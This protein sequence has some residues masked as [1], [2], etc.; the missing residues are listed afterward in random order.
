MTTITNSPSWVISTWIRRG[1]SEQARS[2]SIL[3]GIA[4]GFATL[5]LALTASVSVGL[6]HRIDS[7]RWTDPQPAAEPVAVQITTTRYVDGHQIKVIHLAPTSAANETLP[8]PPGMDH[9]PTPGET[10]VSPELKRLGI[11]NSTAAA[12]GT[13]SNAA[14][15]G[16][17][18]LLAVVG[19]AANDPAMSGPKLHDVMREGEH[20]GPVGISD[21]GGA[22]PNDNSE[23]VQY[24]WLTL[25]ATVLLVVPALS[26]AASGARLSASRRSERLALL[27]LAGL[28]RSNLVRITIA[29]T[30]TGA[31]P[32]VVAG[33]AIYIAALPLTSRVPLV[34]VRWFT[35]DL[36]LGV[37]LAITI[38]VTVLGLVALSALVPLRRIL[39]DPFAVAEH[40]TPTVPHWW[41]AV[42]SV[43]AVLGFLALTDADNVSFMLVIAAFGAVFM[44]LNVI[45]PL[46][47][48][49]IGWIMVRT[50]RSGA[51]LIA[52]RRLLD[53]PKGLWRQISAV[54]LAAF[55]AGFLALFT[56]DDGTIFMGDAHT[57]D[58]AISADQADTAAARVT[59]AL[60][61]A[62]IDTSVWV[63]A[64][65]GAL[66]TVVTSGNEEVS[67]IHVALP[68]DESTSNQIRG[69]LD[70]VLPT[71][72]QAT[73][74]DVIGRDNR[75]AHD[76]RTASL[77]ILVVSFIIA[78]VGTGVIATAAVIDRRTTNTRL[79]RAGVPLEMIDRARILQVT[80]PV[81]AA[82]AMG[83]ATGLI[84]ASPMTLGS[85]SLDPSG[86][87][88]V[89]VTIVLGVLAVRGGIVA[90]R[91]LLRRTSNP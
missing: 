79:R 71:S 39:S 50:A 22:K 2:I 10:W 63:S 48:H 80:T 35:G 58:V 15:T 11:Y 8:I 55:I 85:S 44:V 34:S 32:G 29:D 52:G 33:M 4:I 42:I 9:F 49:V 88:L 45:G 14:F 43:V 76:F 20:V 77:I 89:V 26:L 5:V 54:A 57:L 75:F 60:S 1:S 70:K 47:V 87:L 82:T 73:G 3:S 59:S 24:R 68:G 61:A 64:S 90:S 86:L 37:P 83:A 91:P 21:F 51:R 40:H 74:V 13:L 67:W 27:R 53:D 41:R 25:V 56:V 7:A 81:L 6:S 46:V 23:L 36:W 62:G 19:H 72:A 78:T 65:G 31:L 69:T 30:L 17:D 28:S 16:P 38:C 66:D 12:A 18:E 84:A